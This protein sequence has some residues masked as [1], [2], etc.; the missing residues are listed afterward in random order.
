MGGT[1]VMGIRKRLFKSVYDRSERR[2]RDAMAP[3]RERI[4][5]DLSGHVLEIGCGQGASFAHY[6]AA[7]HVVATDYSDLML[8]DAREA[9]KSAQAHIEVELADAQRLPY[10]DESFDAVVSML[11]LCSTPD[12]RRA[13]AEVRRVLK[14]GGEFRLFEHVRS[15][16]WWVYRLQQAATP[17]FWLLDG[18]RLDRDTGEAVRRAGFRVELDEETHIKDLGPLRHILMFTRK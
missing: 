8:Q 12:Q 15:K 11:V 13:L 7:A 9:A 4:A 5:G 17:V 3:V 14:P 16:R 1:Q 6:P 18:E 10:E 2:Q